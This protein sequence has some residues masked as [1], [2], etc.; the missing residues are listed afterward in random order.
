[1]MKHFLFIVLFFIIII[2]CIVIM[3]IIADI[4][5]QR[6]SN[7][8]NEKKRRPKIN[9]FTLKSIIIIVINKDQEWVMNEILKFIKWKV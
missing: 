8:E 6:L 9:L 5:S 4:D 3:I 2:F 7:K 1:M